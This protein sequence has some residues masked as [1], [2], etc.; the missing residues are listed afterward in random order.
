MEL[1]TSCRHPSVFVQFVPSIACRPTPSFIQQHCRHDNVR[2]DLPDGAIAR[3]HYEA[4]L[5]NLDSTTSP[6]GFGMAIQREAIGRVQQTRSPIDVAGKFRVL[7]T[8]AAGNRSR[9]RR[10]TGRARP[11]PGGHPSLINAN[12]DRRANALRSRSPHRPATAIAR[13]MNPYSAA[14]DPAPPNQLGVLEAP[15][16][17]HYDALLGDRTCRETCARHRR[18]QIGET[19]ATER[20]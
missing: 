12:R 3:F 16:R 6:K 9:S 13:Q 8:W 14:R 10:R 7:Q 20:L 2:P 15:A 1:R 5:G 18:G 17:L 11:P 4:L 19:V